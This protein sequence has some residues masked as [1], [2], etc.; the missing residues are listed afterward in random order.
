M[1]ETSNENRG[2]F[3]S[4]VNLFYEDQLQ[5]SQKTAL[6]LNQYIPSVGWNFQNSFLG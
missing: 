1:I 4:Y 6:E 2:S 5:D 3:E